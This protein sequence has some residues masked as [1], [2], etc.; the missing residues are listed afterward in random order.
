MARACPHQRVS[1]AQNISRIFSDPQR[2]AAMEE[3][4]MPGHHWPHKPG[5]KATI[6]NG[7]VTLE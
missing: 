2:A 5:A 3:L 7:G 4:S 6:L 1:E